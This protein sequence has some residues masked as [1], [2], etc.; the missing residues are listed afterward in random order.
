[1]RVCYNYEH[2]V[3]YIIV[4]EFATNLRG[5]SRTTADGNICIEDSIELEKIRDR[6]G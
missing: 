1:M 3:K 6:R 4:G 5:F 2:E